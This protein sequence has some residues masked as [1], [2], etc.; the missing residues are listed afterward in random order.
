MYASRA[1]NSTDLATLAETI[2]NEA[3]L[4]Q[5]TANNAAQGTHPKRN[6][7]FSSS[8]NDREWIA[9]LL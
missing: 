4:Y 7:T 6:V 2:W 9:S 1:Y 8:C 5:V 3:V